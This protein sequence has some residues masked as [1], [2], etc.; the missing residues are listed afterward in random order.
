MKFIVDSYIKSKNYSAFIMYIKY[1]HKS[2]KIAIADYIDSLEEEIKKELYYGLSCINENV[3]NEL[4]SLTTKKDKKFSINILG[5][6]Y[7]ANE[8]YFALMRDHLVS[9]VFLDE[10]MHKSEDERNRLVSQLMAECPELEKELNGI[11]EETIKKYD[12]TENKKEET[13]EDDIFLKEFNKYKYFIEIILELLK[14]KEVSEMS[15]NLSNIIDELSVLLEKP[16]DSFFNM[17]DVFTYEIHKSALDKT[18]REAENICQFYNYLI[19]GDNR[20]P[21]DL[22]DKIT[23]IKAQ[24]IIEDRDIQDIENLLIS[25]KKGQ[26]NV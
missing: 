24:R 3:A 8:L 18:Q 9:A 11:T 7:S 13:K 12:F 4:K 5:K 14:T 25:L 20:I 19:K 21:T 23:L 17:V 26:K 10:F 1:L 6:D 15:D 2:D 16:V 22:A